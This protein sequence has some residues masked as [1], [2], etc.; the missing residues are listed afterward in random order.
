VGFCLDGAAENGF[1]DGFLKFDASCLIFYALGD[2]KSKILVLGPNQGS[3]LRFWRE[4]EQE[5]LQAMSSKTR[6]SAL[7]IDDVVFV[8]EP[9][10]QKTDLA[11]TIT[12]SSHTSPT[13][14]VFDL[15]KPFEN[16]KR[17]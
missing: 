2:G 16:F 7:T 9:V 3:R 4:N 6:G 15:L 17:K 12:K 5:I 1:K 13:L 8:R 14:N 11:E 10:G